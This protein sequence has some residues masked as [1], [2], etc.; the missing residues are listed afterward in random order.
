MGS[1]FVERLD[2]SGTTFIIGVAG[3]SGSGKTTFTNSIRHLL[4]P[5]R[6]DTITLDDY[7]TQDRKTRKRTGKL[8]LDPAIN[9]L[10]L[11]ARHLRELRKG[12][13]I[14]KPVYNHSNGKLEGPLDFTPPK[15]LIVEG[16]HT[17]YTPELRSQYDLTLYVDPARQV[18]ME[19]KLARDVKK[20]GH[21]P[22]AARAEMRAREPLSKQY[23]DFQ[24]VFAEMVIKIRPSTAADRKGHYG[25]R[26]LQRVL[27]IPLPTTQFH[28]DL[29]PVLRRTRRDFTVEYRQQEYYGHPISSLL[30][31]GEQGH[32]TVRALESQV[33]RF[34]GLENSVFEPGEEYATPTEVVQMLVCWRFLAKL[35]FFLSDLEKAETAH[36]AELRKELKAAGA[37]GVDR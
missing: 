10:A 34:T 22:E 19:W 33:Q 29:A 17:L 37:P 6:V 16:L 30:L 35:D 26:L 21:D 27:D 5:T 36:Q 18:R 20:R 23:I 11:V 25:V 2:R 8:P 1:T 9:D 3:D 12:K 4:G 32:E 13:N 24:K 15:I 28:L 7:H 14:A 31:D